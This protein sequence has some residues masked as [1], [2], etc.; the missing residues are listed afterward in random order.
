[1]FACNIFHLRIQ[2][3]LPT[4]SLIRRGISYSTGKA[5]NRRTCGLINMDWSY[6]LGN[7]L[8]VMWNILINNSSWIR[9]SEYFFHIR[10]D[11]IILLKGKGKV[12]SFLCFWDKDHHL[13]EHIERGTEGI[14]TRTIGWET[15]CKSIT[16]K[17]LFALGIERVCYA[18]K[19]SMDF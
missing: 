2:F 11:F 3:N 4:S 17:C 16:V 8:V 13:K 18:P 15:I 9:R 10:R 7:R 6:L 1:M 12:F 14:G 5:V 19:L